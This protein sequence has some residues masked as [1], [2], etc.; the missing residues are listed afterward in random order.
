V[1]VTIQELIE[2]LS[3]FDPSMEVM[4]LDGE[5][6]NGV[7]RTPNFGPTVRTVTAKDE[8]ETDDCE[9]MAAMPVIALGFGC[10]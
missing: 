6:G 4:I 8:S 2:R 9:D 7:L 3:R 1:K 10:Y 5:N